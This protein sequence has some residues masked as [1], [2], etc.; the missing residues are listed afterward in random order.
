MPASALIAAA[1]MAGCALAYSLGPGFISQKV[2]GKRFGHKISWWDARPAVAILTIVLAAAMFAT[3]WGSVRLLLA[4]P[5]VVFGPT[6]ALIDLGVHRLPNRI[7][8][9]FAVAT[10]V[11]ITVA[12]ILDGDASR[13]VRAGL[14]AL[15]FGLFFLLSHFVR[16]GVG[17]GDVKLAPS[18]FALAG[19]ASWAALGLTLLAAVT[20]AGLVALGVI[21]SRRGGL[22][23]PIAL[24]PWMLLGLAVGL[25]LSSTTW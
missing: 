19:A 8:S 15:F 22:S 12:L 14:A 7:T 25:S 13:L 10:G 3:T 6:L 9:M 20:M 2:Y 18:V 23:T 24:G 17:L 11:V 21:V 16:G 1:C 5:L 4:L